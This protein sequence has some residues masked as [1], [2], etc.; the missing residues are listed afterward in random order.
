MQILSQRDP[1]WSA[2]K[3]KPSS[4]TL[5]R[6]GCTT[7]CISMLS[8][9]YGCFVNPGKAAG[10]NI[11]YTGTGLIMWDK[12]NF[13]NFKFEKRRYGFSKTE[14]DYSLDRP[15]LSV[16]LEVDSSHWVVAL[17]RVPFTN[18][19]WIADPWDGKKKL[20]SAYKKITGSAHFIAKTK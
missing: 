7:T 19:Y 14:I 6:Y 18:L 17:R 1:R 5:G 4:L 9:F 8:D 3:M 20:S 16:I 2:I 15:A 10:E 12:I 13:P 11:K